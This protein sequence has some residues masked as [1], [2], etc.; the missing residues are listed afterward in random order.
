MALN[1]NKSVAILSGTPQRLKS[2]SGLKSVNVAGAVIPLS[3]KIKILGAT[4]DVNLTLAHHIKA[5][6]SSCFFYHIR[7]FRQIRS[8]LDDSTAVSVASALISSR[9]DQ[10]NSILYGIS[11]HLSLQRIQR[12]EARVVLHQQYRT[13][14]LSSNELL[15]QLQWLP[16]EWRVRFKLATLTFKALHAIS[17]WPL[18]L[19]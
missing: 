8:S 11:F 12:A 1:P 4:L 9:L 5:L 17:V 18:A 15:K 14:P 13:Y 19:S 16:I 10:F 2:M 3:D 7:S 6:S